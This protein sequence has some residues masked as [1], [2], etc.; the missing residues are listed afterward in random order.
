MREDAQFIHHVVPPDD[1]GVV[2][3]D[4]GHGIAGA[5]DILRF[6]HERAVVAVGHALG[7]QADDFATAGH[8][9]NAVAFDARRGEQAEIFPVID[10]AGGEL[11]HDQLPEKFAGLFIETHAECCGRPDAAGRADFRCWCR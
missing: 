11:G 5:G 1:V 4:F 3:A 2:R 8:E 6:V 9:I 7:V 10:F